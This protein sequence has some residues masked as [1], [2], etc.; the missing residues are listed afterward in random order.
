M[1]NAY[2]NVY[3]NNPNAGLTDGSVVSTGGVYD[4]PISVSLNASTNESKTVKLAIRCESG[5]TTSGST[6]IGELGDTNNR[7]QLSLSGDDGTWAN[8]ITIATPI[9]ATNTVFWAKASS[10][11]TESP[12]LDRSVSLQVTA[13]IVTA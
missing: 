12:A 5:F 8:S 10:A 11:D 6:T 1:A 4:N 13:T 2:I 9:G 7:W 3:N